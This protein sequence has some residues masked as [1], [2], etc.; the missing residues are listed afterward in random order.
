MALVVQDLS[1]FARAPH[2]VRRSFSAEVIKTEYLKE[3]AA[4]IVLAEAAR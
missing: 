4:R 3:M 1:I 2:V